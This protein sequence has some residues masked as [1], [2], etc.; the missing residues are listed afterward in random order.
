MNLH[1]ELFG[2]DVQIYNVYFSGCRLNRPS[3]E[4]EIKKTK[5][6][7]EAWENLKSVYEDSGVVRL[8]S[9]YQELFKTKFENFCDPKEYVNHLETLGEHLESAGHAMDKKVLGAIMLA[10]LL[11]NYKPLILGFQGSCCYIRP[12]SNTYYT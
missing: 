12:V 3:V 2:S 10:G 4:N 9:L 11:S 1:I 6:A 5:T 8:V 7:K